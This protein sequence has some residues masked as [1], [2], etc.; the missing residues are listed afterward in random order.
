M[1]ACEVG[2]EL[3]PNKGWLH[4]QC[5]DDLKDM[6]KED[7]DQIDIWYCMDCRKKQDGDG[8]GFPQSKERAL[9]D[10]P[11][12]NQGTRI[13]IES[14]EKKEKLSSGSAK[15]TL[16]INLGN[17]VEQNQALAAEQQGEVEEDEDMEL[18]AKE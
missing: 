17:D 2:E 3:C 6:S 1:V 10:S 14:T 12:K 8:D 11:N 16:I 9:N 13:H 5:T 18:E 7:I 4:P 15:K